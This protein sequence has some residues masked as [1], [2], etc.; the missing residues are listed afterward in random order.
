MIVYYS[1]V[2]PDLKDNISKKLFDRKPNPGMILKCMK[3]Y[4]LNKKIVFILVILLLI[5][6]QLKMLE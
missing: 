1:D 5:K 3:K 6:L 2:N 4:N